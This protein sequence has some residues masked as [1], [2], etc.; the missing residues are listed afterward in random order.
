M[1]HTQK[2]SLKAPAT[3]NDF[4]LSSALPKELASTI[5]VK[6]TFIKALKTKPELNAEHRL[7]RVLLRLKHVMF[8]V[9]SKK[10]VSCFFF[11]RMW[12]CV[13]LAVVLFIGGREVEVRCISLNFRPTFLVFVGTKKILSTQISENPGCFDFVSQY[14]AVPGSFCKVTGKV[15]LTV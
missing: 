7:R 14:L 8:F 11:F 9:V 5:A 2:K 4:N 1:T 15:P 10:Q 12:V 3:F 6:P 13:H